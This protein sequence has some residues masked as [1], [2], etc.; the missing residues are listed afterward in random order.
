[1]LELEAHGNEEDEEEGDDRKNDELVLESVRS[2]S[3]WKPHFDQQRSLIFELWDSCNVSIIH[4]TQFF[5]L[6]KGDIADSIYMEVELRR[7]T[8]LNENFKGE[9]P[10]NH[11]SE[12]P[13]EEELIPA[14]PIRSNRLFSYAY[15]YAA[16]DLA[17]EFC[18]RYTLRCGLYIYNSSTD[19]RH[20]A[21]KA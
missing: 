19:V 11:H 5:L 8:W 1:M 2:P 17:S 12:N 6:F 14:S 21:L 16:N 18:F 4:R 15:S 20:A 9:A 3:S 13:I 10:S 7:L